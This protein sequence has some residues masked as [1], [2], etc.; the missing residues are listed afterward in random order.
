MTETTLTDK[1][2]QAVI[3][4]AQMVA[5]IAQQ[6]WSLLGTDAAGRIT[7]GCLNVATTFGYERREANG[8]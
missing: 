8:P 7:E 3:D 5:A 6:C 4:L 1:E 2:R